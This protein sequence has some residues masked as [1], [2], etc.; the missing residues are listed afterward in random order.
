MK[1]LRLAPRVSEKAMAQADKGVY[2]FE[3]P[4]TATKLTVA[5]AVS[6]RFKVEVVSVNMLV[7]KGKLKTFRRIVGRQSDTKKAVV[8]VKAG[9]KIGLFEGA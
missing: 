6:E 5:Q 7:T 1:D 8:K 2:V 4:K 3:V 9:Q